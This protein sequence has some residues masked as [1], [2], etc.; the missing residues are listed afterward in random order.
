MHKT[1]KL[2]SVRIKAGFT[3]IYVAGNLGIAKSTYSELENGKSNPS[4]ALAQKLGEFFGMSAE[5]LLTTDES[6]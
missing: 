4:W 1:L 2:R 3:Q 6:A 5:E